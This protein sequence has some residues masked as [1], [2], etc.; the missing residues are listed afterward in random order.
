MDEHP[1]VVLD[2]KSGQ[3]LNVF[4]EIQESS[5]LIFDK[6]KKLFFSM[7]KSH[8]RSRSV[9]N[10]T[11]YGVGN[12]PS[13][14]NYDY[15]NNYGTVCSG[16]AAKEKASR[17]TLGRS[18]SHRTHSSLNAIAATK[19]FLK[20]LYDTATISNRARNKNVPTTDVSAA[21]GLTGTIYQTP[22]PF[23]EIRYSSDMDDSDPIDHDYNNVRLAL[24]NE[25]CESTPSTMKSTD[26]DDSMNSSS[27]TKS[28]CSLESRRTSF[29]DFRTWAEVFEHLKKEIV[30]IR[31]S[32]AKIL[33]D[34]RNVETQIQSV[35]KRSLSTPR[36]EYYPPV[37]INS[38]KLGNLVE[39]S[40]YSCC[41]AVDPSSTTAGDL[42][43]CQTQFTVQL[44]E[45]LKSRGLPVGGAKAA[46]IDRLTESYLN[47][48][49]ILNA[50]GNMTKEDEAL[51]ASVNEDDV[52][53]TSPAKKLKADADVS[54]VKEA[55]VENLTES[56]AQELPEKKPEEP[57]SEKQK[58]AGLPESEEEKKKLRAE[59]FGLTGSGDSIEE[60]KRKRAERFG[61]NVDDKSKK[62]GLAIEDDE[63]M[64]LIKRAER[65]G[66]EL[67]DKNQSKYGDLTGV[68]VASAEVLERRVKRF[69][70][71]NEKVEL[72]I[73]KQ[74]RAE[75]FGLNKT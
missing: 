18:P 22:K 7:H 40:G 20:M 23:F 70:I 6:K 14:S 12:G 68:D 50:D 61:L 46:L 32:D 3:Q 45:Q 56:P 25:D 5:S 51:D 47:E 26:T 27:I 43:I 19:R 30:A 21:L 62:E 60:K 53:G 72:E 44:R 16:S 1:T 42:N 15:S 38:Q 31:E 17:F 29:S 74:K 34:L 33:A 13:T 48:E 54:D 28:G 9:G 58:R 55:L 67:K 41:I 57:V 65:F 24:R 2:I 4:N 64:R 37:D 35:K 52:L 36:S 69:G 66:L 8:H 49:K 59:R 11:V 71:C 63:K 75:R 10:V 73:K 39:I